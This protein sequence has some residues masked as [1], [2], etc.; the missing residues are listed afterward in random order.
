[1]F[2][3]SNSRE[4]RALFWFGLGCF[5]VSSQLSASLNLGNCC[6][7]IRYRKWRLYPTWVV[8]KDYLI[9]P[10]IINSFNEVESSTGVRLFMEKLTKDRMQT[11]H[12]LFCVDLAKHQPKEAEE[13]ILSI[14]VKE[15][16]RWTSFSQSHE[17]DQLWQSAF[18]SK[19]VYIHLVD[20]M[21]C[22]LC[23]GYGIAAWK[24]S[25]RV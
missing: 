15:R 20:S 24:R 8:M 3:L 10:W 7:R 5:H 12:V 13:G 11:Y 2:S 9:E 18:V 25:I 17:S 21:Y 6:M 16:A 14:R 4:K 1:M 22:S 19:L 23:G